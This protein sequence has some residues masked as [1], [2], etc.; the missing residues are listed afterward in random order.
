[1]TL[2]FR[3]EHLPSYHRQVAIKL[4]TAAAKRAT[5]KGCVRIQNLI[6]LTARRLALHHD[7]EYTHLDGKEENLRSRLFV[8]CS[9]LRTISVIIKYRNTA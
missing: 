8:N 4:Q 5:V 7:Q 3:E 6:F 2:Q 1:M 9:K